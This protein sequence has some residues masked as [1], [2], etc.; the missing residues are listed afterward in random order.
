[1]DALAL[2]QDYSLT[3]SVV[4]MSEAEERSANVGLNNQEAAGEYDV[5]KL[6]EMMKAPDFDH[7]A[8]GMGSS[9][10]YKI[11]GDDASAEVL[12]DIAKKVDA[13]AAINE[14][15]AKAIKEKH[16]TDYY[17]ILIF[18]TYADRKAWTESMGYEDN[19][20]VSGEDLAFDFAEL[21]EETVL[22]KAKIAAL[23]SRK[24]PGLVAP[25]ASGTAKSEV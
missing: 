24:P 20:Y 16:S 19:R 5:E 4:D 25:E 7:E 22:L 15:T 10:I 12:E 3:M 23:E 8:A 1:M 21:R 2:G 18:K 17:S 14:A 11:I 13:A 9:E 6:G